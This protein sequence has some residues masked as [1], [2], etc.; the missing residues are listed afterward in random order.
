VER[1]QKQEEPERA[2]AVKPAPDPLAAI[3]AE[4]EQAEREVAE[5]EE[6]LA[7][8]WTD[9]EAIAAHARAREDLK[10]LLARWETLLEN[11]AEP[12]S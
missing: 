4:I 1:P 10:V 2:P 6:K 8:D 3:E 12:S 5:L 9:T 11:V 7:Q